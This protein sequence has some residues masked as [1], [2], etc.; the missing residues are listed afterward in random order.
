MG[1][2]SFF[3]DSRAHLAGH[4]ARL[5]IV[6]GSLVAG[7]AMGMPAQRAAY[8]YTWR[9]A[10]FC[11]DCHVH[12]YANEAYDRSVHAGVTTCHDCHRVP[13]RHYP[14]NLWLMVTNPPQSA[15]DIHP[16]DVESVVCGQCHLAA[17]EH[18]PLTGPMPDSVRERVVKVD[19]TPLHKLHLE[20]K[21]RTPGRAQGGSEAPDGGDSA[22]PGRDG[23]TCMDCHGA[24]NNRA[25]RFAATTENC[26]ACHEDLSRGT[27]T[28]SRLDCTGCHFEGFVG[29]RGPTK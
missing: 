19:D 15:D 8:D 11:D 3:T 6:G 5:A 10:R 29:D 12:D 27:H 13:I 21:A 14:R 23:I 9:D 17:E 28:M 16:P 20:A 4:P 26:V 7:L 22:H 24:D 2:R 18:E 1:L 25:H